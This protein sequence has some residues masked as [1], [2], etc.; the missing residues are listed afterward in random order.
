MK[1]W[2]IGGREVAMRSPPRLGAV[3]VALISIYFAPVWGTDA[4]RALTSPMYGLQEPA[5]VMA[6]S[7]Y[8]ALFGFGQD[9]LVRTSYLLSGLKFV[10]AIGFLAYLID[11]ARALVIG[12]QPN[13]ETIDAVLALAA[14]SIML[15][16]GPA[17]AGGDGELLR[18]LAIQFLM[19]TGATIVITVDRRVFADGQIE[20]GAAAVPAAAHHARRRLAELTAPTG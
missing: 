18:L 10:V 12:R 16:A 4:L 9:G 13:R 3:N 7:Y 20:E 6:A 2:T 11:F 8:R 5:Q 17:L 14:V 15:S 19:L 1:R